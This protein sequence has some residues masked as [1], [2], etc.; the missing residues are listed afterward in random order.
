MKKTITAIVMLAASLAASG[1]AAQE[2]TF[3]QYEAVVEAAATHAE[4]C[5][6][7]VRIDRVGERCDRFFEYMRENTDITNGFLERAQVE[8]AAVFEGI[9]TT[10]RVQHRFYRERLV[11]DSAYIAEMLQ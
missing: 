2:V 11:T 1:A 4:R 5:K 10:R 3:D 7:E 8:G 6:R 9:S